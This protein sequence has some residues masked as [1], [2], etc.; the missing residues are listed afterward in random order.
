M[1]APFTCPE[2]NE[3]EKLRAS[4]DETRANAARWID[5]LESARAAHQAI[6]A[7]FLATLT[8]A[9]AKAHAETAAKLRDLA[10][11][12]GTLEAAGGPD[13]LRR[14]VLA[15]PEAFALFTA[16]F[17]ARLAALESLKK[18][19]LRLLAERRS[20]V[21]LAGVAHSVL[22]DAEPSVRE[23]ANGIV[24]AVESDFHAALAAR[25]YAAASGVN[26]TPR[27]FEELFSLL[28][29]PLPALPAQADAPAAKGPGVK[30]F[31]W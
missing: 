2:T 16:G 4:A 27:S 6:E 15:A 19:A 13:K 23:I 29:A 21:T 8:P 20:A 31:N 1:N 9:N 18:A 24:A 7:R 5:E 30:L 17:D 22:V 25:N 10:G 3:L 12:V 28:V 11:V 14:N 26:C